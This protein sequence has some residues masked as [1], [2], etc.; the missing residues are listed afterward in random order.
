MDSSEGRHIEKIDLSITIPVHD[1]QDNV[2]PLYEELVEV[3]EGQPLR[4]EI[5]FVNDGSRDASATVLD[6]LANRDRRVTVVHLMRNY[7][8][9]TA[10]MAGFDQARGDVVVVMDGD[11]QNDPADIP[12]LLDKMNEGYT[13][14]S[15]W[16]KI[17]KDAFV[18]KVMPSKV[19]NRIISLVTGVR[20]HDHGCSLKAYH[21]TVIRDLKLYGEMH[22]FIPVF[23]E[24]GGARVGEIVVNHR[25]RRS[26]A[27][28]YGISRV[29]PVLLDLFL[30]R[31][32]Q[33]HMQHPIHFF[34]RF[35]VVNML[36][37]ALSFALMV[38]YKFWGG[39]TFIET[40]LPTLT[41]L[42]ILMGSMAFLLGIV[43]ELVIRTYY[44]SQ[45]KKPYRIDRIVSGR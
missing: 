34:G 14:V 22:R 18:T 43:A 10:M 39:K 25:P 6:G 30:V 26:G 28:K 29:L 7:G 24:G 45:Q 8:Q 32:M 40:P 37:A 11:S 42:F 35:G 27:S 21:R 12:R 2:E 38:Y 19:A 4:F 17:R 16:R 44:E 20:L 9:T 41:V 33:R 1:E 31:F 36:L 5:I 3:L 15:G 23:S 13:V